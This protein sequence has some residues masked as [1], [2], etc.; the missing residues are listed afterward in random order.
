[1]DGLEEEALKSR[2]G[3]PQER[4][5]SKPQRYFRQYILTILVMLVVVF[6]FIRPFVVEGFRIPT[7]SMVPTLEVGDRILA[8]KFIYRFSEPERGDI[9]V[10]ESPDG[11]TY[12]T[13]RVLGLPGDT[14]TVEHGSLYVNDERQRE[15]YLNPDLTDESSYGPTEVPAGHVFVMGDNRA[16]S[17]DSRS[18]GPVPQDNIVGEAFLRVWPLNWLEPL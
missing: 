1:M 9:I 14:I 2:R 5:W 8:N 6:G 11:E 17:A 3:L 16:N 15:T 7:Q 10:F 18:I 12:L 13:K 4:Q